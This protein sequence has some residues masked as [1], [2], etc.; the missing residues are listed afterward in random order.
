MASTFNVTYMYGPEHAD[1]T[2]AIPNR[3]AKYKKIAE[4]HHLPTVNGYPAISTNLTLEVVER[5]IEK[6]E[7]NR[8]VIH[9]Q[10]HWTSTRRISKFIY[11]WSQAAS[12][13]S[14]RVAS[15]ANMLPSAP[16]V[17]HE[18]LGQWTSD[19]KMAKMTEDSRYL[20]EAFD[21]FPLN[22][23]REVMSHG[24]QNGGEFL[25]DYLISTIPEEFIEFAFRYLNFLHCTDSVDVF[26]SLLSV[27]E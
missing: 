19:I 27:L 11:F 13:S 6:I 5:C 8:A 4:Q 9:E 10:M 23:K 7:K 16:D 12:Y 26:D 17:L 24:A 15:F 14:F 1:P 18:T 20:A 2:R 21:P 3:I 22:A 25:E